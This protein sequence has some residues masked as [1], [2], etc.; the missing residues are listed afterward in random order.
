MIIFWV[1]DGA[2]KN[3]RTN[4]RLR[5]NEVARI[6]A[7]YYENGEL[8]V[9]K[10][11]PQMPKHSEFIGALKGASQFHLALPYIVVIVVSIILLWKI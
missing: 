7:H 11:A 9:D 1:F 10:A 8:P 4:Y 6:L 2:Y 3:Y 5:R